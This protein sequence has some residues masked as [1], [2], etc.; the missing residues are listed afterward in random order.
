MRL[1][2]LWFQ[3]DRVLWLDEPE[4]LRIAQAIRAG[5]YVD[6]GRWLRP[7]LFPLWLA[8][9]LGPSSILLA[10]LA[11]TA[12]GALL[13]YLLYRVALAAWGQQNIALLCAGIAAVYLPLIAYSSYLMADTLLLVVLCGFLLALIRLAQ[14]PTLRAA[15]LAGLLLGVAALT[16]PIAL[17]CAPALLLAIWW[18]DRT[19][20]RALAHTALALGCGALLIAPWSIRNT[21]VH[22][23]FVLLDTTGGYNAWLG[24]RPIGGDL[25]FQ[26]QLNQTYG[27][28]ADVDAA[29]SARALA[30]AA[31]DPLYTI[32][33]IG[34]KLIRFWRTETDLI[35]THQYGELALTC[36]RHSV[37]VQYDTIDP[38][39]AENVIADAR[40]CGQLLV[41]TAADLVYL[42]VLVGALAA[43][44]WLP[45]TPF[46]TIA[47]G[48]F[49]AMYGVMALTIVQPRLRLATLP[50]LLPLAAAGLL[51]LRGRITSQRAISAGRA[52]WLWAQLRTWR[53]IA[54][55]LAVLAGLWLL[56]IVPLA[57]SQIWQVW[58]DR[59]WR[60]GDIDRALAGYRAAASWY[61]TRVSALLSA[62]QAAEAAGHDDQALEFYN[63]VVSVVSY[64]PQAHIGAA[65]IWSRR[66]AFDRVAY[67]LDQ[68]SLAP[69]LTEAVGFA[70]DRLPA[71]S[72][73]DIG[74]PP[75]EEYGY[76]LG[77]YPNLPGSGST[78][79]WSGAQM[80]LRFGTLP[81]PSS[82]VSI[83]LSGER[84]E[85]V[86]APK[87]D[88]L[89]D[90]RLIASTIVPSHWRVY[91]F[92]VPPAAS[93]VQ[94]TLRTDTY[95]PALAAAQL[96]EPSLPAQPDPRPLGL[97]LDWAAMTPLHPKE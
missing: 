21:L 90:S 43:M 16:K 76:T 54:A 66:G 45:R 4:Y 68:D 52:R 80:Q 27:D 30:N 93:G 7:P 20:R 79:R 62:G 2:W 33:Q 77:L 65:R 11:Q 35:F 94:I 91:R 19:W 22:H 14:R 88:V 55:V 26:Q 56:N 58:G 3:V 15:A 96:S 59:A 87:L 60:A 47:W 1:A 81:T 48:W 83:R 10:K 38:Q 70:A 46:K 17:A 5:S 8:I 36:P 51:Y 31:R 84:P 69:A 78:A 39:S 82:I 97:A 28:P 71:R 92:V 72:I 12:L 40:P 75:A 13:I 34:G 53:A 29:L 18:G 57:G 44:L 9:T 74:G 86:P 50:V 42:P 63:A 23:R 6:G 73:V 95:I 49:L 25:A 32:T 89:I 41:N 37:P 64:D 61:P 67:E 24:N 85:G